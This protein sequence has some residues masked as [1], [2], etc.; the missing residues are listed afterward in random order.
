MVAEV[1]HRADVDVGDVVADMVD[2]MEALATVVATTVD[3]GEVGMMNAIPTAIRLVVRP[4]KA[5]IQ[6]EDFRG[7]SSPT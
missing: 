7:H 1:S 6:Q 3:A 4:T 5:A 2:S